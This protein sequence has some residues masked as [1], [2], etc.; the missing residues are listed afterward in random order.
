MKMEELMELYN[1]MVLVDV[2]YAEHCIGT[3]TAPNLAKIYAGSTV[4][5]F[6]YVYRNSGEDR[7]TV[8]LKEAIEY[9]KPYEEWRK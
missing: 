2:V 9:G 8:Y 4:D 1:P 6:E 7:L 3:S 5:H